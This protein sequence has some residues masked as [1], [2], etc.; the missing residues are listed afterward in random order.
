MD[1]SKS[2]RRVLRDTGGRE[3]RVVRRL[4]RGS[5]GE[6]L[7]ATADAGGLSRS[8]AIKLLHGTQDRNDPRVRRLRDEARMLTSLHHPVL[9][10]AYDLVELDGRVALVTEYVEGTDLDDLIHGRDPLPRGPVLDVIEQVADALHSAFDQHQIVHRDVKPGNIRVGVHGNVKLLDFGIA[11]AERMQRSAQTDSGTL[12][13]TLPYLAPECFDLDDG[14]PRPP[15]DVFA[16]GCVLYEA[17]TGAPFFEGIEGTRLITLTET[18]ASYEPYLTKQLSVPGV[19]P[20]ADLLRSM[21]AF[22]ASA[23]P[24]ALAVAKRCDAIHATLPERQTLRRWA[25]DRRGEGGPTERVSAVRAPDL[26]EPTAVT[27]PDLPSLPAH[28]GGDNPR[29]PA[30]VSAPLVRSARHSAPRAPRR[31]RRRPHSERAASRRLP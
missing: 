6:I 16:L 31:C 13:G 29:R 12:L 23:R 11:H 3:Y 28:L 25:R 22:L 24:T 21:L 1:A 14:P 9:L 15:S 19:A 5:V 4:G 8:V 17:W 2:T 18:S 7:L 30:I 27:L 20:V 10:S 26:D